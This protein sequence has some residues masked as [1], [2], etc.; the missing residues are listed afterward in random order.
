MKF[1]DAPFGR[2]RV[3]ICSDK[4]PPDQR[5]VCNIDFEQ[6]ELRLLA[7]CAVAGC[8]TTERMRMSEEGTEVTCADCKQPFIVTKGEEDFLRGKFGDDFAM[9][10]RCKPCRQAKKE[11]ND[12][13]NGRRRR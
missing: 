1:I 6:L 13:R 5:F 3:L 7:A 2:R 9:P 10:K 8:P 4:P 12:Q 11:R